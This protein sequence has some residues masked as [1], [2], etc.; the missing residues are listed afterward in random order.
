MIRILSV[1]LIVIVALP[2]SAAKKKERTGI[3][4]DQVYTDS[5]YDFSIKLLENWSYKLRK[6]G[7]HFRVVLLQKN[8]AIPTDYVESPDYTQVPRLTI[9]A[10][11]TSLDVV[12]FVDSLVSESFKSEQK[13]DIIKEFDIFNSGSAGSGGY[14]ETA[15]PRKRTPMTLGGDR[16]I[17]W[18]AQMKYTVDV[19][20]SQASRSGKTVHGAYGG[21]IFGMRK[22][23][24]IVLAHLICE[25]SYFPQIQ[26]EVSTMINSFVWVPP[27][28]DEE[29]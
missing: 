6:S 23:N 10:D 8:Y 19:T 7:D 17:V 22:G 1:L 12:T 21:A 29:K 26:D 9:W 25:W 18:N 28:K 13:K 3:V 11:T 20:L 2:V 27:T 15:I 5:E 4:T 14:R 16:G 24:T